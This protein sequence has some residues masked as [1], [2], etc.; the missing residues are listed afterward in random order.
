MTD[1]WVDT[2]ESWV[3]ARGRL[4]ALLLCWKIFFPFF[5]FALIFALDLERNHILENSKYLFF[6]VNS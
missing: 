5:W 4:V 2:I 6:G 3:K 1:T